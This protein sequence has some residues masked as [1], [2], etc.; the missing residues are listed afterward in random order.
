MVSLC[1]GFVEGV[2]AEVV[3]LLDGRSVAQEV[4]EHG[5]LVVC[6]QGFA[7]DLTKVATLVI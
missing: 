6:D 7:L 1:N 4:A 2:T 5:P 3:S